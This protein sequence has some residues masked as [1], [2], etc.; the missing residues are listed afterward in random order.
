MSTSEFL[1]QTFYP[2]KKFDDPND[3]ILEIKQ[4]MLTADNLVKIVIS[5]INSNILMILT[6]EV[7][8]TIETY[9]IN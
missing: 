8:R 9:I 5:T 6:I 2:Y 1:Y 4:W 3:C 7:M